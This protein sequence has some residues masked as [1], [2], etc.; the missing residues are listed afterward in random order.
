VATYILGNCWRCFLEQLEVGEK[1]PIWLLWPAHCRPDQPP[2]P[3]T[4]TYTV[5]EGEGLQVER[6]FELESCPP[7]SCR[8]QWPLMVPPPPPTPSWEEPPGVLGIRTG[9]LKINSVGIS[10]RKIP[11]SPRTC[12][13]PSPS[14]PQLS[15]G[16]GGW[17]EGCFTLLKGNYIE[18]SNFGIYHMND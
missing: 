11:A 2:P 12:Y 15:W 16:G 8:N 9:Y 13:T 3:P 1:K 18:L 4:P 7:T 17:S 6:L 5:Y 14:P 10:F